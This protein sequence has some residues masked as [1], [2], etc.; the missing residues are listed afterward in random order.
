[1]RFQLK[2]SFSFS[3]LLEAIFHCLKLINR[4]RTLPQGVA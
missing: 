4:K 1:V 2:P 3:C